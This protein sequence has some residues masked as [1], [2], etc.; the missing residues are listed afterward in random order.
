MIRAARLRGA[1]GLTAVVALAALGFG[2]RSGDPARA[3]PPLAVE[4]GEQLA[5]AAS[6]ANN[7]LS[8][9]SEV[10]ATALDRGRRGAAR[11]VAGDRP[12]APELLAAAQGLEADAAAGDA[13]RRA[14]EALAGTAAAVD[15]VARVPALSYSGPELL[16][17]AAQLRSTAEAAT[18]FVERRNATAAVVEALGAGVAA[19]D[20]DQP[21]VA[22]ARLD[23][24]AAPLALL[25]EWTDRP[26]LLSYWMVI[27]G[28]LLDAARGIAVATIDDDPVAVAVAAVRYRDAGALAAGADNALAV[29]LAEG[30]SAVSATPLQRLAALAGEAADLRAE[31]AP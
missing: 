4:R 20:S 14:L 27:I 29:A 31:L 23:A 15:P 24:A 18:L 25:D 1:V 22:L 13:A 11:T 21:M 7:A 16:E 30:A 6:A 9:L 26:P 3:D 19:L 28:R 8:R 17:V 12:P 2:L 10:L 5:S